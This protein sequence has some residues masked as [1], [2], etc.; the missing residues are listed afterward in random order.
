MRHS[1]ATAAKGTIF[2]DKQPGQ[3]E[4]LRRS[5]ATAAQGTLFCTHSRVATNKHPEWAAAK[6]RACS[7]RASK[8]GQAMQEAESDGESLQLVSE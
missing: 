4:G 2:S 8:S 7:T 6:A 3:C 1:A 5:E